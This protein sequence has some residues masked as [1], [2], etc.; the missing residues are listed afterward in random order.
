[1]LRNINNNHINIDTVFWV[2]KPL[3]KT[4]DGK[5]SAAIRYK[6]YYE[7]MEQIQ[8]SGSIHP[9]WVLFGGFHTQNTVSILM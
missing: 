8:S 3:D 6:F 7:D 4:Q 1:M 2:W 9:T 5:T